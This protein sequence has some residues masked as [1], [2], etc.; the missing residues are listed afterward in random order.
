[1]TDMLKGMIKDMRV[2]FILLGTVVLH[3]V[4]AIFFLLY[5]GKVDK[6]YDRAHE[7]LKFQW[8]QEDREREAGHEDVLLSEFGA[9]KL[10][11]IAFDP[12]LDIKLALQKLCQA[13]MPAEYLVKVSVDR[14]TE[15]KVYVNVFNMPGEK[16]LAGYLKDV[17]SHVDDRYVY[18]VIF[19]DEERF[20]IVDKSQLERINNWE[21][22]SLDYV[23][24]VCLP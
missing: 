3:L 1:M 14:F 4:I 10:D 19:T 18:Q 5:S 20:K 8:A 21:K 17:F 6:T 13:V 12:R 23:E 22:T 15:F 9:T 24:R 2:V 11:R 7:T 16:V